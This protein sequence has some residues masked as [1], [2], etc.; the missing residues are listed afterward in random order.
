MF[1]IASGKNVYPVEKRG[2]VLGAPIDFPMGWDAEGNGRFG[3][4][5]LV[6]DPLEFARREFPDTSTLEGGALD[7]IW[8]WNPYMAGK[9]RTADNPKVMGLAPYTSE[10][11]YRQWALEMISGAGG[12]ANAG[13]PLNVGA[14]GGAAAFRIVSCVN[15][16]RDPESYL[17]QSGWSRGEYRF[18]ESLD[19]PEQI[20]EKSHPQLIT[21]SYEFFIQIAGN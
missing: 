14:L 18:A 20:V 19:A 11:Q 9:R 21:W 1:Q 17:T 16:P 15:L 5:K 6:E 12:W 10:S 8:F 7:R 2:S 13:H 3:A 4:V